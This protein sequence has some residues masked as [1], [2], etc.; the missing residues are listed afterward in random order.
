[1]AERACVESNLMYEQIAA[2]KRRAVVYVALF[3][4]IWVSLGATGLD[5]GGLAIHVR[6]VCHGQRGR[7]W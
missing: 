2:N 7:F 6:R 4:V 1:V 3:F 5:R